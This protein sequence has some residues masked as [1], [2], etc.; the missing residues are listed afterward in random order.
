MKIIVLSQKTC[1]NCDAQKMFMSTALKGKPYT[2]VMKEEEPELFEK[3]LK[4]SYSSVTPTT[5]L[6]NNGEVED[7]IY[8]FKAKEIKEMFDK[9]ID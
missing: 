9:H 5:I 4:E 6:E 7:V 3:Y 8:G 1:P 2:I